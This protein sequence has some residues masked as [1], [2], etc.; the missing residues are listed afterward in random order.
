MVRYF[1]RGVHEI[2][3][4]PVAHA[5]VSDLVKSAPYNLPVRCSSLPLQDHG[6][7]IDAAIAISDR[8]QEVGTLP[9]VYVKHLNG[10]LGINTEATVR[11]QVRAVF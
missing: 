8:L 9:L 4:C 6:A 3:E 2:Y 10:G 5:L 1:S 7:Q 11:K